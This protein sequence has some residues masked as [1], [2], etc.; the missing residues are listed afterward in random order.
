MLCSICAPGKAVLDV[1]KV[2]D[3]PDALGDAAGRD[4]LQVVQRQDVAAWGVELRTDTPW[5]QRRGS[6]PMI[7]AHA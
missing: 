3:A 7:R 5:R 1:G 4:A 6:M 2:G